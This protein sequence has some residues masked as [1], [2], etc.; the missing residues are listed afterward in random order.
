MANKCLLVFKMK[1]AGARSGRDDHRFGFVFFSG[2]GFDIND[3]IVT[4][5]DDK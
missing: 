2:S 5:L 3:S 4:A 1:P